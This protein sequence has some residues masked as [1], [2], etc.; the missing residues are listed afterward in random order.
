MVKKLT[1]KI[2]NKQPN[3]ISK[4]SAIICTDSIA[5]SMDDNW[6]K[7]KFISSMSMNF[8]IAINHLTGIS[9]NFWLPLVGNGS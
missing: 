7:H 1:L 9:C 3:E 4:A 8:D 5:R 6:V 2:Y